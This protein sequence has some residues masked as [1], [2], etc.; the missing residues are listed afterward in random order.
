MGFHSSHSHRHGVQTCEFPKN[1]NSNPYTFIADVCYKLPARNLFNGHDVYTT[2]PNYTEGNFISCHRKYI[3]TEN[4]E[5]EMEH[6]RK[7]KGWREKCSKSVNWFSLN[8][9]LIR[10]QWMAIKQQ[11]VVFNKFLSF[12]SVSHFTKFC[13]RNRKRLIKPLPFLPLTMI[14]MHLFHAFTN[15]NSTEQVRKRS[16]VAN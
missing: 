5:L 12:S 16:F 11:K 6:K 7:R 14:F 8:E 10:Y 9:T 4:I 1:R 2:V 13:Q 15:E 3:T